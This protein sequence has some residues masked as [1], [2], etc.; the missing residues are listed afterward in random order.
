M[1]CH[2]I[3]YLSNTIIV[4]CKQHTRIK[5]INVV[6]YANQSF[7]CKREFCVYS[8]NPITNFATNQMVAEKDK[9]I[10]TT[11]SKEIG[12]E[13]I[14][15]KNDEND[16]VKYKRILLIEKY[17]KY[18]NLRKQGYKDDYILKNFF[19]SYLSHFTHTLIVNN[20]INILRIKYKIHVSIIKAYKRNIESISINSSSIFSPDAIFSV[21]GD[22]TYLESAHI[23]ANKY[24]V[25]ENS[26]NENKPIEVVG[27]NSD[28]N[29]S[30]GKLCLDY[31]RSNSND[32]MNYSYTSF[33][34]FEKT[35]D[36]KN[37]KKN[38]IFTDVSNFINEL[39]ERKLKIRSSSNN[40]EQ[41]NEKKKEDEAQM[42]ELNESNQTKQA[43][44]DLNI[45]EK[46]MKNNLLF[47][48]DTTEKDNPS[49]K[50]ISLNN[51]P[52]KNFLTNWCE[53]APSINIR[54]EEY[55]KNILHDFFERKKY[56]KIYRKYITVYIKKSEED[57]VK[58]YKSI[59]EVYI[60]EA[61]KNNICT[62]VNIDN[63]I[64]KKLKS[65]ALLIT[66]GTGSTAWAYNVHKID[67]KKIKNIIE[68]YLNIHND[69]VKKNFQNI[70]YDAFSEYIN[71]SICFHPSSEYM[72][73]II[74]EPVEN[75]VYDATDH[76]YN[77]K[78]ID[79]KTY[80]NNTIVYIDGI[81][82]IK[83]QPN[84]SVILHIKDD[85]YIVSYK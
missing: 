53:T 65:T 11:G 16:E 41:I 83:I 81:Y 30:E 54:I 25:D 78:Y 15:I 23:I 73:C 20:I 3:K 64:V 17:T 18:D 62:Y 5:I 68:E 61:V 40:Y 6:P 36:N 51:I 13:S 48:G 44:N 31:C 85:D 8:D 79:I 27:I 49:K 82:N 9:H 56:K 38:F 75:N 60:H 67:K 45:L 46:I 84:D 7:I 33:S 34:E 42:E 4:N 39:K 32:D 1:P 35:Y 76:L 63:K 72:K 2:W 43:S 21:G 74:K 58:T 10:K 12:I 59:N 24:I 70:N 71:N 66:S 28:P 14:G 22:G 29:S 57:Q 19:S 69:E 52:I 55:V 50:E 77:C 47:Y 80:T 26:N 37:T